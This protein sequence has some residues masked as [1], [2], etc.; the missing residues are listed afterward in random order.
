[1]LNLPER[2]RGQLTAVRRQ[3]VPEQSR[4]RWRSP[5]LPAYVGVGAVLAMLFH[6]R[7]WSCRRR[8]VWALA[9]TAWV[10]NALWL[11]SWVLRQAPLLNGR[12]A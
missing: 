1:M 6:W 12:P 2:V 7:S 8:V 11:T 4:T 10:G 9:G 3:S 5:S